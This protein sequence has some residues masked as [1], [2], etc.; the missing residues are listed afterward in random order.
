MNKNQYA[1]N[2]HALDMAHL[3]GQERMDL[4]RHLCLVAK[5]MTDA[6]L[7]HRLQFEYKL[8]M[9]GVPNP[10]RHFILKCVMSELDLR[11]DKM[12]DYHLIDYYAIK[13]QLIK[14]YF[15]K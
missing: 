2:N 9:H 7:I 11:R 14:D 12:S 10:K 4:I 3:T 5:Q 8:Y 15:A 13:E 6:E 1:D